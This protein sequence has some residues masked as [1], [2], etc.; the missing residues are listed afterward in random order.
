VAINAAPIT[1]LR[2]ACF[3]IRGHVW[4]APVSGNNSGGTA[5]GF[6]VAVF[7]TLAFQPIFQ[8]LLL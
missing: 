7:R 5:S 8:I 4:R 2:R 3:W 6:R 1:A